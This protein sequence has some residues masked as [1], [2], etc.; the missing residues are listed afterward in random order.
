MHHHHAGMPQRGFV[1]E[2]VVRVVAQVVQRD[3]EA[4]RIEGPVPSA[5]TSKSTRGFRCSARVSE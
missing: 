4:G 2:T 5:K 3:I 1:N